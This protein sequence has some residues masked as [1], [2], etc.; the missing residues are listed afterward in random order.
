MK[1]GWKLFVSALAVGGLIFGDLTTSRLV[2]HVIAAEETP[3]EDPAEE[4]AEKPFAPENA[5]EG[6]RQIQLQLR[7]I[8]PGK[9]AVPQ[10]RQVIERIEVV[11]QLEP[12][13]QQRQQMIWL[14][15]SLYRALGN[16]GEEQAEEQLTEYL[17][18]LAK[19]D[20]I[21]VVAE[22]EDA[23]L[24]MEFDRVRGKSPAERD[25]FYA[26]VKQRV[27]AAEPD[28][29][30]AKLAMN[31]TRRLPSGDEAADSAQTIQELA[32]HFSGVEDEAITRITG[33]LEGY[34]RRLNLPGNPI[35]LVGN[36]L[37]G[38]PFDWKSLEGKV[39][40]VDFWATWCGPC[41]AEIPHLK[42]LHATYH[43]HGF[44]IVGISL[45][46]QAETVSNFL[47]SREVPWIIISNATGETGSGFADPNAVRY[48]ISAIPTMILVGRD[49]K[50]TSIQA[51]GKRLDALLASE[52][53]GVELVE[54]EKE[55][56]EEPVAED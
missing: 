30:S 35:E 33:S 3:A 29:V 34:A 13:L 11:W 1:W 36:T 23:I 47:T 49:G 24:N 16:M 55:K 46:N 18:G 39:V 31:L 56:K 5:T 2:T 45:D 9:D 37:D 20:Q 43:E 10:L 7:T 42:K 15:F 26:Q 50:V 22:A 28:L 12:T 21:E 8:K 6:I 14:N 38:K 32:D 44:E 48:G 25:A 17:Q 54:E 41:I 4:P 40:L 53:P 52:F 19:S 27:L 51:R